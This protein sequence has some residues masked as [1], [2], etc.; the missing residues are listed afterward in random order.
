VGKNY[1]AIIAGRQKIMMDFREASPRKEAVKTTKKRVSA[2]ADET[3]GQIKFTAKKSNPVSRQRSIQQIQKE[4]E[5]FDNSHWGDSDEDG[6]YAPDDPIEVDGDATDVE[7]DVPLKDAKRRRTTS[8]PATAG[9]SRSA[10]A[11]P[12]RSA[13]A[14]RQVVDLASAGD[15]DRG[16]T[17]SPV[18][19][20]YKQLKEMYT[21]VST[22]HVCRIDADYVR[23]EPR[24]RLGR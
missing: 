16:N 4:T 7:E 18:D 5:D 22:W 12:S 17:M 10:T 9:P 2:G 13:P 20:A 19:W 21:K 23:N 15:L 8:G 3:Q 1:K 24:A 11:G 14:A 6:E